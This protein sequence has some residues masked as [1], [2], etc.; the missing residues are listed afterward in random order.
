MENVLSFIGKYNNNCKV[1]NSEITEETKRS[2]VEI[3]NKVNSQSSNIKL[4][5]Y[6]K[7]KCILVKYI[8]QDTSYQD[9]Q[10]TPRR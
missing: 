7:S 3:C 5:Y 2:V 8:I 6:E 10:N 4:S 1:Y 9:I